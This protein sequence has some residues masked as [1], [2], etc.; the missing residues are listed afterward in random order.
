MTKN[1]RN[2]FFFFLYTVPAFAF[3]AGTVDLSVVPY[4]ELYPLNKIS[5][6]IYGHEGREIVITQLDT[7]RATLMGAPR[8]TEDLLFE[9]VLFDQKD[10]Y[11]LPIDTESM[12]ENYFR[13]LQK[14]NNLTLDNVRE[15][16]ASS[17]YSYEEGRRELGR[18]YIN[19]AIYDFL[20][21]SRLVVP[22]SEV[23]KYYAEN[24]EFDPAA[25]EL[26][27][28]FLTR[29]EI[30]SDEQWAQYQESI[31]HNSQLEKAPWTEPLWVNIDD[32]TIEKIKTAQAGDMI[33]ESEPRRA[34]L[35][36]VV[37]RR[38]R[39]L[40]TIAE[41]YHAIVEILRKPY[42]DSIAADLKKDLLQSATIVYPDDAKIL[43]EY[44]DQIAP[45]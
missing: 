24:P 15:L 12:V 14:Q 6:I 32:V 4:K 41:R 34:T 2:L 29:N 16:F 31:M 33:L 35:I 25:V 30:F 7:E 22:E 40:K 20:I 3:K 21:R 28:L 18:M 8:T 36:K 38:E 5:A 44:A 10:R 23:I 43:R 17:G 13:M 1:N 11:N 37:N 39:R 45:V 26:S 9:H 19:N 27:M 42:F